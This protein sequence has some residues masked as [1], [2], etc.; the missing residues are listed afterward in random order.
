MEER[1]K[2]QQ[3]VADKE[4][5]RLALEK[6]NRVK[7]DFIGYLSHELRNPLTT[8]RGFV[9]TLS[10][11]T[12]RSLD[13]NT[14]AEFYETIEAEADRMLNLINELLDSSRLEAGRPLSLTTKQVN[15]QALLER[16]ARS[17]RFSKYWT[18]NHRLVYEIEQGIP[19]ITADED[20]LLQ[21]VSNLLTN[22]IKYSPKGG[23]IQL[24]ARPEVGGVA[25]VV[26]D[27]GVGMSEEHKARLFG[28]Y[29]R[30]ERADIAKI[31]GTGLGL[32]LT[33]RLVELHGGR[34]SCESSPG[35][36]SEFTV[37]LPSSPPEPADEKAPASQEG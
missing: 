21:I 11:D 6:A 2:L 19:E 37:Y 30:L 13:E 22:A 33:K 23:E 26:R 15:L 27:H 14:K 3:E 24:T 4:T 16:L 32:Y 17:Q 7:S 31:E 18:S 25:I 10:A 28:Q 9:Q 20:K 34:I 36:G 8:I 5:Q 35:E 1:L 29:E 12:D